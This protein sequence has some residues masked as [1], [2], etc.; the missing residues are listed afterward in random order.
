MDAK[1]CIYIENVRSY[2]VSNI[3]KGPKI[4][5]LVP[6]VKQF[7]LIFTL[8]QVAVAQN[9]LSKSNLGHEAFIKK[10]LEVFETGNIAHQDFESWN[11]D[12]KMP[13]NFKI[14]QDLQ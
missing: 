14:L 1:S 9:I 12:L 3:E 11:P 8:F 2:D 13:H 7:I 5:T 6:E 10:N 4:N